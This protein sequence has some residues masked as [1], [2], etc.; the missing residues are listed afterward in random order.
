[1]WKLCRGGGIPSAVIFLSCDLTGTLPP[2]SILNRYAAAY[3]FLSGYTALVGSTEVGTTAEIQTTFSMCFGA[4][5]FPRPAQVYAD[6]LMKKIEKDNVPVYLVNTGWTGG[7][8]GVGQRFSIPVTRRIIR[9]IQDGELID[10]PTEHLDILNLD[11]P[12]SLSGVDSSLLNPIQSYG[13]QVAYEKQATELADQ[14]KENI[15]KFNLDSAII[16]AG[17]K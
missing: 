17:P 1:M 3:H 9:A 11:I 2:V 8:Y 10:A 13:D 6:L 5:F 15:K 16:A 7:A 12:L 14:F 4:P